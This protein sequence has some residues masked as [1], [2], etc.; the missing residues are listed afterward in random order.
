MANQVTER[1]PGRVSRD[2]RRL[3]HDRRALGAADRDDP[4]IARAVLRH[5]RGH[6]V[7]EEIDM[8]GHHRVERGHRA[9]ERHVDHLDPGQQLDQ[10]RRQVRRR[11]RAL[12]RI[13]DLAGVRLGVGDQLPDVGRGEVLAH[14]QR[15]RHPHQQRDRR[16]LR[17]IEA[18]VGIEQLHEGDGRGRADE[19]RVAVRRRAERLR[20]AD[21]HAGA[22]D[23]L[24]DD[25]LAPFL[26]ELIGDHPRQHVGGRSGRG[27][28]DHFD[29]PRRIGLLREAL[30]DVGR[31]EC[32]CRRTKYPCP[33]T[34]APTSIPPSSAVPI[35]L[36][37]S[38]PAARRAG[39]GAAAPRRRNTAPR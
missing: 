13:G 32:Q 21:R 7:E 30:R 1:K 10:V 26:A 3:R 39:P 15:V 28:Q 11:A 37:I 5:R 14:H 4:R 31:G 9:A 34:C 20:G 18:D 24:D 36:R 6:G 27:R 23:V 38:S 25:R 16:E 33:C 8:S 22:A 12:R 35:C 19:Q 2:R 29:E 17:R